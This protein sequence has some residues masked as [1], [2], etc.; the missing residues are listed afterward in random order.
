MFKLR[1]YTN[2]NYCLKQLTRR[3]WFHFVL[4]FISL[5]IWLTPLPRSGKVP[6]EKKN[7]N[8]MFPIYREY[9]PSPG[10]STD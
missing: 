2:S 7:P 6:N 8:I 9:K 1:T 5:P 10:G 4:A 3:L